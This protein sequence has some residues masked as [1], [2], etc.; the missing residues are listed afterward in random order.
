MPPIQSLAVAAGLITIVDQSG[1]T[2]VTTAIVPPTAIPSI[3]EAWLNG[4]WVPA[5]IVGYQL[6]FHVFTVAPHLTVAVL[7][8]P[9]GASVPSAIWWVP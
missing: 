9:F 6:L 5:N 8:L 2:V 7:T 1:T 3:A 4:T